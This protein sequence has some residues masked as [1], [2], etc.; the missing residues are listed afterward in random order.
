MLHVNRL[1]LCNSKRV[2]MHRQTQFNFSNMLWFRYTFH[3]SDLF[4]VSSFIADW[5]P[6]L[7]PI[8]DSDNLNNKKVKLSL[9]FFREKLRYFF[10]AFNYLDIF[11]IT[12]L[13][14]TIILHWTNKDQVELASG[15]F[16]LNYF[17]LFKFLSAFRWAY[18]V[19][20]NYKSRDRRK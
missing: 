9:Y 6:N 16:L 20:I 10:D 18:L 3:I 17:R 7:N 14:L 13:M 8:F 19:A 12:F 4:F 2:T 1:N 15:A 11:G 5:C